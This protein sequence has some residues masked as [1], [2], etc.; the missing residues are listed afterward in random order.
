MDTAGKAAL[1]TGGGSGIGLG[2]A[3]AL[4]NAGMRVVLADL[5]QDHLDE[6][7][8]TLRGLGH[9]SR[10][11]AIRVDV[12]DRSA[13]AAAAEQ[14]Q[15][16]VGALHVL[17]NNAGIGIEV[18]LLEATFRDWDIGLNVNLGGVINGLQTFLPTMLAHGQ[19]GHIVNTASLAAFV[20][21]P[22]S[23]AIYAA[24]KAA[25]VALT[26]SIRDELGRAG[27]GVS[28]LCPGPVKSRI[29]E[30]AQN[31]AHLG[32]S[33]ALLGAAQRLAG[34]PVSPLWMEPVEVGELVLNAVRN[35]DAYIITH[36][37]WRTRV[38]ERV[39]AILDAM[40][41]TTDMRLLQSLRAHQAQQ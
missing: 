7:T 28:L 21:M 31:A 2:I 4:L 10:V 3:I 1:I 26:E 23:M 22:A 39:D 18:P 33:P 30:L 12:T 16:R 9:S 41:D 27:I 38:V 29:H 37:E 20:T 34:R 24:S 8:E 6:A 5:R 13:M 36:G 25:V 40:P 19:G 17:V 32:P 35:N 15:Q 11:H 14:V